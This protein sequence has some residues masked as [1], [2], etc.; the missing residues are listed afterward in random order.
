MD[1]TKD[2][3]ALTGLTT[4]GGTSPAANASSLLAQY[5]SPPMAAGVAFATT[6]T[7]SGIIKVAESATNDNINRQPIA[8]K[9]YAANGSSLQATLKALG[10]YG[11][12]T[13]EWPTTAATKEFGNAV[14]LGANYT[15]VAG[16]VLVLEFGAQVDATGG[17]SVTGT[18]TVGSSAASDYALTEGLTTS[19]NPWFEISRTIT[20]AP[21]YDSEDQ[22]V[23]LVQ[24]DLNICPV[25][26]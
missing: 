15:T 25:Y 10:H 3:S 12:T 20:F 9:V 7:F 14:A 18:M 13:T 11:P 6:D 22:P 21:I 8:L 2:G 5:V 19:L 24:P 23:L 26:L 4:F 17:T 1:T 16:D